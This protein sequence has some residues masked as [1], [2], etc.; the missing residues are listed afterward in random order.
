MIL[1]AVIVALVFGFVAWCLL[2]RRRIV[3]RAIP[4]LYR[5][6]DGR[7]YAR[8]SDGSVR[9]TTLKLGK[10][11]SRRIGRPERLPWS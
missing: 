10:R 9:R 3:H 2:R 8:R 11:V 6:N 1:A 7:G 5:A 4:P